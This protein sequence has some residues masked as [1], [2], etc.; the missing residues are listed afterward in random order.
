MTTTFPGGTWGQTCNYSSSFI[1]SFGGQPTLTTLAALPAAVGGG[2]VA[3]SAC[4]NSGDEFTNNNGGLCFSSM[5]AQTTAVLPTG[6]WINSASDT[7]WC[8]GTSLFQSSPGF[9]YI[10]DI[11]GN[12]QPVTTQLLF[13]NSLLAAARDESGTVYPQCCVLPTGSGYSLSNNCGAFNVDASGPGVTPALTNAQVLSSLTSLAIPVPQGSWSSSQV[14]KTPAVVVELAPNVY[15][16]GATL[17]TP[18]GG[19]R[20]AFTTFM[21]GDTFSNQDGY[22]LL[23]SASDTTSANLPQGSWISS[24]Y[25]L[26]WVPCSAFLASGSSAPSACGTSIQ[27]TTPY[28]SCLS[29]FPTTGASST[30]MAFASAPMNFQCTNSQLQPQTTSTSSS[31]VLKILKWAAGELIDAAEDA[32]ETAVEGAVVGV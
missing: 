4:F 5:S 30:V 20:T 25:D 18:S 26:I 1:A 17:A 19:S 2:Y 15:L 23:D 14:A 22:F 28:A 21:V 16:L 24:A 11:A 32:V 31:L 29:F 27:S 6:S 3:A 7:V 8:T 12:M 10:R 13:L 9:P